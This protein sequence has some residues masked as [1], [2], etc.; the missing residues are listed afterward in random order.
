MT[1]GCRTSAGLKTFMVVWVV[2]AL[3]MRVVSA[4]GVA[5]S[6]DSPDVPREVVLQPAVAPFELEGFN[7]DLAKPSK[8]FRKEPETSS[9]HVFRSMLHF[10]QDTNNPLALIWDQPREKLH[11]DLNR[12]LDLTDDAGG[13]ISSTNKGFHQTFANVTVP[14]RTATGPQPVVLDLQ[15]FTDAKAVWAYARLSSRSFWQAKVTIA[16]QE[17]QVAALANLSDQQWPAAA[18]FLLLRPWAAR[19]NRA[20]LYDPTSG[21]VPFP[22]RLFW[23]GKAFQ[24][25][26]RFDS[27]GATPVCKLDFTPQQPLLAELKLSGESIYYVV[28]RDT[29]GFTAVLRE[30]PGTVRIPQGSYVVSA[31]WLKKGA[32]EAFQ[33]TY[34]PT[35][36]QT[37]TATNLILGGPL[38]NW[39]GLNRTSRK[40]E[41]SYQLK[42]ADGRSY[43]LAGQDRE[44]PPQFTVY[45]G[46]K[47]ALAGKFEF[48]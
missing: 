25:E 13:A 2:G 40:L 26:R 23:L 14:V 30:P 48:G 17:W 41:I 10:G 8:P 4:Q 47:K 45:S 31:A 42:G 21:I 22:G 38:T 29:N 7:L 39:V 24:L 11:L 32:A 3:A 35:V 12:N 1:A 20:S 37:G 34:Q 6:N 9:H 5:G 15:C 36:L 18:Q 19:T 16:G 46:G 44:K 27:S 33:Q 28:L 43:W